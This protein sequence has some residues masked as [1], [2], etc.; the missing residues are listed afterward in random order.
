MTSSTQSTAI[1]NQSTFCL[2]F[3]YCYVGCTSP[4]HGQSDPQT[5]YLLSNFETDLNADTSKINDKDVK[6]WRLDLLNNSD[7]D[8]TKR[9]PRAED[10]VAEE[11]RMEGYL[12]SI[13]ESSG[14]HIFSHP[15]DIMSSLPQGY[16]LMHRNR[17]NTNNRTGDLHLW[18]HPSGLDYNS[19]AKF[20]VHLKWLIEGRVGECECGPCNGKR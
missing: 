20:V 12:N 3:H 9:S 15:T 5:T 16:A 7:G 4:W 18:G 11:D 14:T 8:A 10:V 19:A 2:W 17:S 1:E 6:V 13:E